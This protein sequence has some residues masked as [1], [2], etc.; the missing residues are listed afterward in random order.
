MRLNC[1]H[2]FIDRKLTGSQVRAFVILIVML[3]HF[4]WSMC[5]CDC[6]NIVKKALSQV[7]VNRSRGHFIEL[8]AI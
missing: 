4:F 2:T 6:Q 5:S 7:C 8:N 3:E 1:K